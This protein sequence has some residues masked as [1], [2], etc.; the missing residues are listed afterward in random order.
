[1]ASHLI[2]RTPSNLLRGKSPFEILHSI[3]SWIRF[4]RSFGCLCYIH[5]STSDKFQVRNRKCIFIRYPLGKKRWRVYDLSTKE[6]LISRD[7]IL[8]E[9]IFPFHNPSSVRESSSPTPPI[10]P[11]SDLDSTPLT[12]QIFHNNLAQPPKLSSSPYHSPIPNSPSSSL[13]TDPADP[14]PDPHLSTLG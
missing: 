1:M 9:N 14:V 6:F 4:L 7:V 8:F 11:S 3:P 10:H 5:N 12:T 2:N 13:F